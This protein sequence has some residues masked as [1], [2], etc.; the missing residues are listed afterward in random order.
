V[1]VLLG[2]LKKKAAEYEE[3]A[4]KERE[5]VATRL[6]EKAELCREWIAALQTWK[7][8]SHEHETRQPQASRSGC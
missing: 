6:R 1:R 7:V 2:A 3:E 5:P 8:D 4:K